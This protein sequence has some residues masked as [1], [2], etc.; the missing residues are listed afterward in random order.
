MVDALDSKSSEVTHEGSTPSFGT[1]RDIG[2]I[3]GG[4][5]ILHYNIILVY[6]VINNAILWFMKSESAKL[7][8][9]DLGICQK[10]KKRKDKKYM[11]L[12]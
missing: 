7:G 2:E 3:R 9:L 4:H 6:N 10:L 11:L 5:T 1:S 12:E 8:K